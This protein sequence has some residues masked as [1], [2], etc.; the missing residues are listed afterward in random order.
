MADQEV[1]QLFRN[2]RTG[3]LDPIPLSQE[4]TDDNATDY[5]PQDE[6]TQEHYQRARGLGAPVFNAL[7]FSL[8][9]YMDRK[10]GNH[11]WGRHDRLATHGG[12]G[13]DGADGAPEAG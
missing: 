8:A 12:D 11:G 3:E 1:I 6:A 7:M 13:R 10:Y 5:I 9:G 4:F 2:Y